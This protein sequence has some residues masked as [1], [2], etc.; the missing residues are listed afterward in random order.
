MRS[1]LELVEDCDSFPYSY[2]NAAAYRDIVSPLY[3]LKVASY[4]HTLGYVPKFV[5]EA[6]ESFSAWNLN[7]DAQTLTLI[8][9]SNENERSAVVAQTCQELRNQ[10]KF[11]VLRG[12]RNELYPVYGPGGVLLFNIERAASAL[13]GVVSYGI[14]MTAYIRSSS[15]LLLWVPRRALSKQTYGG[16]LDN[17]VAG[18][19]STGEEPFETLI[20]EAQEEASLPEALVR[21]KAKACGTIT[22]FH[23]RDERAGGETG[24][25]QPEVQYVY[26]LELEEGVQPSPSDNEV[27]TFHLW[28][29][30]KV[31]H[32]LHDGQFKPNCALVLL[33]FLIRH[34]I[35]DAKNE[36]DYIQIIARIHRRLEFPT[37]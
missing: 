13:L 1:F 21:Q 25:L 32:A 11:T 28:D 34:G 26:D 37:I 15:G 22:Y 29:L 10:D 9:G 5:A 36:K 18:G 27:E 33:D 19:I 35:L 31:Q 6:F 7:H 8:S 12:W 16:M 3:H 23:I 30:A 2:P 4:D 17:T 24:L 20:R 14:H